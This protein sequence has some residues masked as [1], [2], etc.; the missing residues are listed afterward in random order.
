MDLPLISN[1]IGDHLDRAFIVR[2]NVIFQ[3]QH[4]NAVSRLSF[5]ANQL[6]LN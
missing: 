2:C 4:R 6:D 5:F 3:E 1:S